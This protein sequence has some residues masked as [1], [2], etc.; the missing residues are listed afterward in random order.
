[1]TVAGRP[2][3]ERTG[4][5]AGHAVGTPSCLRGD[6][7]RTY[8]GQVHRSGKALL[9]LLVLLLT[10]ACGYDAA[11]TPVPKASGASTSGGSTS[12]PSASRAHPEPALPGMPPV[13]GGNV[14]GQTRPE[15][16]SAEAKLAKPYV[17]VPNGL[18]D[19]VTVIDQTTSS[20]VRTFPV[21]HNPEHVVPSYDM[22]WLWVTSDLG[23]SLTKIDPRTGEPVGRVDVEDPY[24]MYFTPD[25]KYSIVVAERMQRL[26]F[27]DPQTMALHDSTSVQCKGIDHLDFSG[28]GR[29]FIA[30]CEF[31]GLLVKVDTETH[32]V[33]GYLRIAPGSQPQD[34]RVAS[35]GVTFFVADQATNSV[36]IIDGP[37]FTMTG[38]LPGLAGA[39][40]LYPS[41]DATKFYLSDRRGSAVTV[42]D[43]ASRKVVGTWSIPGGG[44][45]DMGGVSV[46]GSKLWLSGRYTSFIYVWDTATGAF[47]QKIPVGKGPHGAS[48]WPQPGR[49][50]LGHTTNTR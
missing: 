28:D 11:G 20:V 33:L 40:G 26:D 49:Y 31:A 13:I 9:P 39:H 50:S 14:Y 44:S 2:G 45:P 19:T 10:T 4:G 48:V 1:M 5:A 46:D 30:T 21:G 35:D 41:R 8:A 6:S 3:R 15:D 25:G 27:R 17:Y 23:N 24:N 29:Y 42:I 7:R 32:K 36:E 22:R 43:M 37:S 16:L 12:G 47:L 38:Q 18:S 34:I